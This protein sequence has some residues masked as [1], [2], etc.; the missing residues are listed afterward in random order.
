MTRRWRGRPALFA[1]DAKSDVLELA[2]Y[3]DRDQRRRADPRPEGAAPHHRGRRRAGARLRRADARG[4]GRR[5]ARR[6]RRPAR[7]R[8]R[9]TRSS[10]G[11]GSP[12]TSSRARRSSGT[13]TAMDATAIVDG[14]TA[15]AERR[16][17]CRRLAAHHVDVGNG[18]WGKGRPFR[19]LRAKNDVAKTGD[20]IQRRDRREGARVRARAAARRVRP[21]LVPPPGSAARGA[22][23][24]V[25]AGAR[26]PT[27]V[28]GPEDL[29]ARRARA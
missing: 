10:S 15:R 21:A 8:L 7:R 2:E 26:C 28:H 19:F 17:R 24:R 5:R 6:R 9:R 13:S 4:A 3:R 25:Q 1:G 11:C 27:S 22:R 16:T 14:H 29:R 18:G 23:P 12:P 20:L